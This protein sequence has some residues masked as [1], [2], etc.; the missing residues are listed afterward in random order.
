MSKDLTRRARHLCRLRFQIR[1]P[2]IR[3]MLEVGLKSQWRANFLVAQWDFAGLRL[4]I[5]ARS[6]LR[7]VLS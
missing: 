1:D 3:R 4:V 5:E 6:Q 2:E 7:G